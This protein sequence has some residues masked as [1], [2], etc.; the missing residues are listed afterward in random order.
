MLIGTSAI[1][2]KLHTK[3]FHGTRFWKSEMCQELKQD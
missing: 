2:K 3:S 1:L